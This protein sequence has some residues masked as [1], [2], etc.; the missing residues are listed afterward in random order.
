MEKYVILSYFTLKVGTMMVHTFR[1]TMVYLLTI[2][3]LM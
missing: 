1:L 3:L 2:P